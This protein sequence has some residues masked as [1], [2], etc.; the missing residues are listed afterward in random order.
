MEKLKTEE[1]RN[2]ILELLE[3]SA[4]PLSGSSLAKTF[5]VSRQVIVTDMA[6]LKQK[7]P[8]LV[9][10]AR[11]YILMRSDASRCVFKVF[12]T[13]EQTADELESIV[14]LGGRVLDVYV[15]HK[16][17]GTIRRPLDIQSKRDVGRFTHDIE[18]GVSTPLMNI[19]GGYHF[20]T[21]EARSEAVLK[22]IE[23]MLKEKGYLIETLA[24]PVIYEPKD[25]GKE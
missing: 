1:R 9:A 22:E 3:T 4:V 2:R 5:G 15:D 24:G 10:T 20:H 16:V 17:Y 23:A 12:H 18:S 6:I 14:E 25:Y 8:D 7:V 21:V 19:T 13:E 11:G